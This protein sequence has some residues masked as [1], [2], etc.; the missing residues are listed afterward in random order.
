MQRPQRST[1]ELGICLVLWLA[2]LAC[3]S[4]APPSGT[5]SQLPTPNPSSASGSPSP[6]SEGTV[7]DVEYGVPGLAEIYAATGVTS[8]KLQP[9]FGVWGHIE[10]EPGTF[11]WTVTDALVLEYQQAGFTDIQMLITAESPWA[12]RRPPG[13]GDRGDSFPKDAYLEA[14]AAFVTAFVERYDGDGQGDVPGLLYPV[15]HYGIERE[16]T[17]FWP[18]GDAADYVRL[19]QIAYPAIKA[20][21]P[22][23]KVLLVALLLTDIFDGS[24]SEAEVETR[25]DQESLLGYSREAMETLLAACDYYDMVDFHSLG[26]YSEIP[27]TVAWIRERLAALGC[28]EK[29]IW[30]GDSFS[31]SALTGYN[32]PFGIQDY[33][34]FYPATEDTVDRVV[35]LLESVADPDAPDHAAATR[36]LQNQMAQGLVKKLVVSAGEGLAGI[37][38]GNLED[39]SVPNAPAVTIGLVRSMGTSVFM[40]M[41]DRKISNQQSGI[42]F[43]PLDPVTKYRLPGDPRPAYHALALFISQVGDY[44]AVADCGE[45]PQGVWCYRFTTEAGFVWV[46]WYDDGG[47]TF[48][49]ETRPSVNLTLND[50]NGPV[51]I[52]PA[53]RSA[54][55]PAGEKRDPENGSLTL[56]LDSVALFIIQE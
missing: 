34:P 4:S 38:I 19:L 50:L 44:T 55:A 10:P 27:P 41:I 46:L 2:V 17:G 49:G 51:L 53:P 23:A 29:P 43:D 30:I 35:A 25:L 32:D 12:S 36:W 22:Q 6:P 26:D 16:F 33:R 47:M 24:P 5:P 28:S 42:P 9:V 52:L 45:L 39:W 56:S 40:G 14:Y 20:A 54:E 21:D 3:G 48:P 7:F 8:V 18:S 15:R 13:L 31:M 1:I 11:N 37:N